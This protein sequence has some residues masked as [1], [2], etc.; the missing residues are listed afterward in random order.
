MKCIYE[1]NGEQSI[2]EVVEDSQI[3][4][5]ANV[6]WDERVSGPIP[7]GY[8]EKIGYLV[9]NGQSVDVDTASLQKDESDQAKI[10]AFVSLIKS[11]DILK[12]SSQAKINAA[13]VAVL[14]NKL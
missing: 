6:I 8:L 1:L 12:E 9:K 14:Q 13:I 10:E 2:I 11:G 3:I 5:D 7:E 4:S